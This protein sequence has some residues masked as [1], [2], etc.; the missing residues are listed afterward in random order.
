M[1]FFPPIVMFG[2][3]AVACAGENQLIREKSMS[4]VIQEEPERKN[5]ERFDINYLH[6]YGFIIYPV[7]N[8][9]LKFY[10]EFSSEQI[11]HEFFTYVKLR[12]KNGM[13][14]VCDCSGK[15]FEKDGVNF[16][17]IEN[18]RLFF[19]PARRPL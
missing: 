8:F 16:Y 5:I 4:N 12:T 15:H 19:L 17:R 11:E 14:L 18:A 13:R 6:E 2:V 9:H 3:L 1:S 10:V 7:D